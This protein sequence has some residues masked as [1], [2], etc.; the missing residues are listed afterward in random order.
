MCIRDRVILKSSCSGDFLVMT[1]QCNISFGPFWLDKA[2]E[3]LHRDGVTIALRPKAYA[4]LCFLLNTPGNLVT[5]QQLLDGVWPETFVSDAVLKDCIRQLR[6]ALGDEAKNP[7]FIE[8]AHRRG[9]RFIAPLTN[10][11]FRE[12]E[13]VNSQRKD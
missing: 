2:N 8:T 9:Y 3:C 5:K 4:V 1:D 11:P 6:E 7:S 10:R 12:S 13:V